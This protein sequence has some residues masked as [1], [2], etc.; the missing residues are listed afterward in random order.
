M[1][2]FKTRQIVKEYHITRRMAE[3]LGMMEKNKKGS[4]IRDYFAD[5]ER[6]Y[7]RLINQKLRQKDQDWLTSRSEGKL[8]RRIETDAIDAL[9]DYAIRQGSKNAG[10][11]FRLLTDMTHKALFFIECGIGKPNHFKQLFKGRPLR[12][13]IEPQQHAFLSTAE[14]ICQKAIKQGIKEKMFYRD[15]YYYAKD[16]VEAFAATVGKTPLLPEQQLLWK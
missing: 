8:V 13:F 9:K 2:L 4:E 5:V 10:N 6:Q 12:D 11:Y 7:K 1:T 15:I 16:K 14:Y 3:H